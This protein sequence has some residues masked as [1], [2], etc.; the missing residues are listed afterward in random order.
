MRSILSCCYSGGVKKGLVLCFG[1]LVCIGIFLYSRSSR[2]QTEESP[3]L[4]VVLSL[5]TDSIAEL[6]S[7]EHTEHDTVDS[8]GHGVP[9]HAE[10]IVTTE[11]LWVRGV[12]IAVENAPRVTLHH[13]NVMV[14][15]AISNTDAQGVFPQF[16]TPY[17][18][19][20]GQDIRDTLLLSKPYSTY[21]PK[22]SRIVL[23][24]MVHNPEPPK[25]PG[26]TYTDVRVSVDLL[27]ID[28]PE[29]EAKRVQPLFLSLI[30]HDSPY[31]DSF[32]VPAMSAQYTRFADTPED[33]GRATYIFPTD[34]M[35][36][37]LGAHLH[38]WEGGEKVDAYLNGK[39]IHTFTPQH[40][41][42]E[43][44]DFAT[45]RTTLMLRVKKGDVLSLSATYSN[46]HD[47]PLLGAMG[48]LGGSF[49][50]D[51]R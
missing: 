9:L 12:R 39:V 36:V 18:I 38:A 16:N 32:K 11:D 21:I 13:L 34:G 4:P 31:Q 45:D 27:G 35:L 37:E 22:G 7:H 6:H 25:G 51:I 44:W 10:E 26:G 29:A 43:P 20:V 5:A 33:V 30:D 50:P 49:A 47:E 19:S 3:E 1:I 48:I 41:G 15:P 28:F 24:G 46:E 42:T 8:A 23:S 14:F 17:G 2:T 40:A